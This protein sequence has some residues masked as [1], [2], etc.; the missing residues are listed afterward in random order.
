MDQ[1]SSDERDD[2]SHSSSSS[3]SFNGQWNNNDAIDTLKPK[4]L[5]EALKHFPHISEKNFNVLF[6][7]NLEQTTKAILLAKTVMPTQ[8]AGQEYRLIRNCLVWI[9]WCRHYPSYATLGT[10]F[11]LSKTRTKRIIKVQCRNMSTRINDFVSLNNADTLDGF[12]LPGCVGAVDSAELEIYAWVGDAYSGK[13]KCFT[14]KYQ[15]TVCLV[16]KKPIHIFGPSFG[17]EGDTNQWVR[18][19]L[20]DWLELNDLWVIGDKGYVGCRRVKHCLKKRAGQ[21]NLPLESKEYNKN[22][23]QKRVFVENHFADLKKFKVLSHTFRGHLDE[24]V[25][26]FYCCEILLALS[27]T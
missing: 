27:R 6:K 1:P 15:V 11:G 16:T 19:E 23:S 18:S 17:K 24:H 21:L 14:V 8:T 26:I 25:H 4:I 13:A 3:T 2:F 22:I 10:L 9:Y 5:N 20:A 7:L 12:F